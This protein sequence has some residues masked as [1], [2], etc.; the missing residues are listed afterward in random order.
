MIK[1]FCDLC[2][3]LKLSFVKIGCII[4]EGIVNEARNGLDAIKRLL[5]M[6]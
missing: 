3:D 6:A 5:R 1:T 4:I 2:E